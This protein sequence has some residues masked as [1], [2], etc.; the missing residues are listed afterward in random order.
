PAPAVGLAPGVAQTGQGQV[1]AALLGLEQGV[2]GRGVEGV[3][4]DPVEGVGGQHDQAAPGDD[5]A[6]DLEQPRPPLLVAGD[7]DDPGVL[8][9]TRVGNAHGREP[10]TIRSRPTMS[11]WTATSASPASLSRAAAAA[12]WS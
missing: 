3:A 7:G 9:W 12:A 8:I 5:L 4:A 11:R 6:A 2:D 10:S 1:A